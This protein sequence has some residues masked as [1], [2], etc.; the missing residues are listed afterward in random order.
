[1]LGPT[2]VHQE[3]NASLHE[4]RSRPDGNKRFVFQL[5]MHDHQRDHPKYCSRCQRI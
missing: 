4:R 2:M 3:L 1:V 5:H